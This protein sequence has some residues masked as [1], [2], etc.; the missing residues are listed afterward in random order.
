MVRLMKG[1]LHYKDLRFKVLNNSSFTGKIQN[2]IVGNI[3][4]SG[5]DQSLATYWK[6]VT[7]DDK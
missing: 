5:E 1:L 3:L 2:T 7:F 6:K 4:T